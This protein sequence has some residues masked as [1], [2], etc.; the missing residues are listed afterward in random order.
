MKFLQKKT[1]VFYNF[2]TIKPQMLPKPMKEK[3]PVYSQDGS[4]ETAAQEGVCRVGSEDFGVKDASRS[5]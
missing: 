4:M 3:N 2:I 5:G 1:A